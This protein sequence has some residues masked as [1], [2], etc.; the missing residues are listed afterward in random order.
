MPD[1]ID[2]RKTIYVVMND[3]GG[4]DSAWT[5]RTAAVD[6]SEVLNSAR[7]PSYLPTWSVSDVPLNAQGG[8]S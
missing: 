6:R 1:Q 3:Q 8:H 5:I 2:D 4:I 7:K